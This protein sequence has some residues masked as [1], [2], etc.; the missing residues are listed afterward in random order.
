[1]DEKRRKLKQQPANPGLPGKWSLNWCVFME[2]HGRRD[3]NKTETFGFMITKE[4]T[5]HNNGIVIR[6]IWQ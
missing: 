1:M 5:S 2:T 4:K 3:P 6:S